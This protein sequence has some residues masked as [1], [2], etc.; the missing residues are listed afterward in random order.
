MST[1]EHVTVSQLEEL[2]RSLR[3]PGD[4]RV[5]VAFDDDDPVTEK[6]LR[7]RKAEEAIKRLRGSGNGNLVAALLAE[8]EKEALL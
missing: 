1:V 2:L 5:T 3:L 6:A 8:R 4:A 7:R